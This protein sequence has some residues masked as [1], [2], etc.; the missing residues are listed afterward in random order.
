MTSRSNTTPPEPPPEAG[1]AEQS[2]RQLRDAILDRQFQP[3]DRLSVPVIARKF[4]VSRSPARE[5]ITRIAQEGLATVTRNRGAVVAAVDRADL[6]EIY[7][8]REMLEA[9]ACRLAA[10]NADAQNL[11]LMQ[12]LLEQHERVVAA[13]DVEQHYELDARFHQAIREVANSPRLFE[14]LETLQSQIRLGMHTTRRSPGGMEQAA[15]E[16]RLIFT[17]IESRNPEFAEDSVRLHINRLIIELEKMRTHDESGT[18]GQQPPIQ[19]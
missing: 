10:M 15:R 5:A 6:I 13:G 11:A 2:Y 14:S 19:S 18:D 7:R 9:L 8:I 3:G 16:H 1:L 4:G 17:G 12:E